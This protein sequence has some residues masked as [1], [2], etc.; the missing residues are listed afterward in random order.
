MRREQLEHLIRAAA[1]ITN[2]YEIVV[3]GSQSVLGAVPNAPEDLLLSMEADMYPLHR[4]ELADLI[5]GSIGEGSSFQAQ[6]GYYAEGVGPETA[7][8]PMGWQ[9]RLVRVQNQNTDGKIGYCLEPHDL[10]AAKLAA[11]REK[12]WPFVLKMLRAGII[13]CEVLLTRL[14]TLPVPPVVRERAQ[15]WVEAQ[16]PS[17]PGPK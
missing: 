7:K 3:V 9:S 12:D 4:P 15:R 6:F 5:E 8:L 13:H 10:A 17:D 16:C 2:E 14:H 1:A 11:G